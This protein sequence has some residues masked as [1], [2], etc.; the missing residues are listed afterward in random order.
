MT[1]MK[2]QF[3]WNGKMRTCDLSKGMDISISY[4]EGFDQVNCFYAPFF[5]AQEVKSGDFIGSV[6]AGG[7]VNFYTNVINIH[8]GGTHTE[9]AGH[10]LADR[11]SVNTVNRDYFGVATLVSV[12]P[13][14]LE[15]GDRVITKESLSLLMEDLI[16]CSF[17]ILRTLPNDSGKMKK[18][19]S[20]TNPAYVEPEAAKFLVEQ[21][22]EHLLI[23]LP[24]IDREEDEGLL[25]AHHIF[26]E[27][28]RSGFCTITELVFVPDSIKDGYYFINLQ[29]AAVEMDATP[30]RP[31]LFELTDL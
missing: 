4:K 25:K 9:C 1:E 16:H 14:K 29:R 17:V 7:P 23:D 8:G 19:Y 6:A 13:T 22:V 18:H 30:S 27:E 10:I 12:Y 28:G 3:E 2:I 11:K 20:G 5:S 26:W 21:G 15:N 31:L 24:S